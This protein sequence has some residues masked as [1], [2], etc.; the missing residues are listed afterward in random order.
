MAK[1][2]LS[3]SNF[4]VGFKLSLA[5]PIDDRFVVDSVDD[6]YSVYWFDCCNWRR[7]R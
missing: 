7:F 5:K 2:Y 6:L 3:Q 1:K 4:G